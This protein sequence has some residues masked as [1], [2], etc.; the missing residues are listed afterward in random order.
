MHEYKRFAEFKLTGDGAG[1]FEGYA[2]LFGVRDDGG[3]IVEA[4]AFRDT[5][6]RFVNDG[7]ISLGHDWDGLAIGTIASAKEDAKGLFIRAEY[8]STQIAQDART[9]AQERMA[10]GKSV[11]LSIGYEVMPGG[12]EPAQDGSRHL[13]KLG[14]FE[15]AQVNV[16]M[17]R[18]AGLTGVKGYG[19]PFEDHSENVRVAVRELVE[20]IASGSDARFKEGRAMSEARRTR[21]AAVKDSLLVG[22][23]EIDALLKETEPRKEEE[24]KA[25]QPVAGVPDARLK[26]LH[27]RFLALDARIQV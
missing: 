5:L 20:R 19:L 13:L 15:V 22:A 11:G 4:G 26:V 10:K 8:H 27:E 17:L 3:D 16:P 9:V 18:P 14:L 23:A 1:G 24:P 2:S 6:D 21:I 12:A 25:V 7:F